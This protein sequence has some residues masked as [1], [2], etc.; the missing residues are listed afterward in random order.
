MLHTVGGR[1]TPHTIEELV[2][3]REVGQAVGP[4]WQIVVLQHTQRGNTL[5]QDRR[6]PGGQPRPHAADDP[7]AVVTHDTAVLRAAPQPTGA[8]VSGLVYDV[9]TGPVETAAKP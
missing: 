2:M 1:A 3:L 6:D 7:P 9:T 8:A 4:G 5:I